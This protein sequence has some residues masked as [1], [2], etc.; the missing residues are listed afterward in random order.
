MAHQTVWEEGGSAGIRCG[1]NEV[2]V[3]DAADGWVV[4]SV[5]GMRIRLV[6]KVHVEE[7]K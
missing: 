1:D 2:Q 7:R 6:W 4:C 5:C 3:I